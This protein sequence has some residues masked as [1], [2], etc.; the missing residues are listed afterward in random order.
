MKLFPTRQQWF[1]WTLP[2]KATYV[3]TWIGAISLLLFLVLQLLPERTSSGNV[4]QASTGNNVVQMATTGD[5]SPIVVN[6]LTESK[7]YIVRGNLVSS[8]KALGDLFVSEYEVYSRHHIPYVS[9]TVRADTI[10]D[11]QVKPLATG[12]VEYGSHS[13]KQDDGSWHESIFGFSGKY[14]LSIKTSAPD[15][16]KLE[17]Q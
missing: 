13:G 5:N 7:K 1:G 12:I 16:I 17:I 11:F 2:S 9:F 14:L 4:H 3:G 8:N 15:S 10:V 6:N